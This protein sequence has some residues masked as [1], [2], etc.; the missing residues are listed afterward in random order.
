[1]ISNYVSNMR[2]MDE[3][4]FK[5]IKV[6]Q[7]I[8]FRVFDKDNILLYSNTPDLSNMGKRGKN[9]GR[10][11]KEKKFEKDDGTLYTNTLV[12]NKGRNYYIEISKG[13]EDIGKKTG[14]LGEILIITSILGTLVSFM[15]GSILS[16][17]ARR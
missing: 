9:K 10:G 1:M 12:N 6:G 8:F 11:L 16:K 7:G 15:S 2:N 13:Y 3:N 5:N 14:A 4:S 17:W